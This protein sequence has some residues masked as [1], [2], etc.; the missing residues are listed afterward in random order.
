MEKYR[1]NFFKSIALFVECFR[2][3]FDDLNI[4]LED[5]I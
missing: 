3:S 1:V 4:D 2:L 5:Y